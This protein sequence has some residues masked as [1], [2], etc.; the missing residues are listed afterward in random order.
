MQLHIVDGRLG[1]DAEV[2]TDK[3]GKNYVRFT[4]ANRVFRNG[5]NETVWYDVISNVPTI[6]DG[7]APYLKKGNYVIVTGTLSVDTR[8]GTNSIV[9]TNLTLSADKVDFG[10]GG[11]KKND[12]T[13]TAV[14]TTT[15]APVAE[16]TPPT[17]V[18]EQAVSNAVAAPSGTTLTD[19]SDEDLPF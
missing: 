7:Q 12:D 17:R 10:G 16:P 9:Y 1:K 18:F 5:E 4:L 3:N 6:V 2:R 11:E 19:E 15:S 8:I 14:A 13:T